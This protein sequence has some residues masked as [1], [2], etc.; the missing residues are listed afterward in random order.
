ME[1][2]SVSHTKYVTLMACSQKFLYVSSVDARLLPHSNMECELWNG[3]AKYTHITHTSLAVCIT[4]PFL[5]EQLCSIQLI[6][7][8]AW[9]ARNRT[10]IHCVYVCCWIEVL[11]L[12]VKREDCA[13]LE[14]RYI[15][16]AVELEMVPTRTHARIHTHMGQHKT[17]KLNAHCMWMCK[18]KTNGH[19]HIMIT[20]RVLLSHIH[21]AHT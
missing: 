15:Y 2:A 6:S 9:N 1:M 7:C 17:S 4:Q 5:R 13:C 16:I 18:W 20:F 12:K 14:R 10:S 8:V 21:T 3:L 11:L 19:I